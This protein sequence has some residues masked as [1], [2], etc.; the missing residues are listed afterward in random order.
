[1][2]PDEPQ[3]HTE[4]RLREQASILRV[5]DLPYLSKYRRRHMCLFEEG[6]SALARYDAEGVRVGEGEEVGVC[7]FLLRCELEDRVVCLCVSAPSTYIY[8]FCLSIPRSL[9]ASDM[10][11]S[12]VHHPA[13]AND[14]AS[15]LSCL[16]CKCENAP[17]H[18]A[19][20]K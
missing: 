20:V 4:A 15:G 18:D 6:D 11:P 1:M 2:P 9:P 10:M 3:H 14:V 7:R 19:S 12:S 13:F 17:E 16:G 8:T 5:C